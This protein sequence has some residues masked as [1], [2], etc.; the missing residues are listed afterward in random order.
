M[1][2]SQFV[3][4]G[5]FYSAVL[6]GMSDGLYFVDRRRIITYWNKGAEIITG[7]SRAEVVGRSCR[8]N[9]LVHTDCEGCGLCD[10]GCPLI[11][12]FTDGHNREADVFLKHKNGHRVPVWVRVAP[13]MDDSGAVVGG[14]EMFSR[15]DSKLAAFEKASELEKL[16]LI[17]PVTGVGNRRHTERILRDNFER[18][19]RELQSFAVL[20]ID[21]DNFKSVNDQFG[22]DAG[23]AVLRTMAMTL[24]NAVRS[25]DFGGRWGGDEFVAVLENCDE[26]RAKLI[27]TRFGGLARSC[28]VD[29][30]DR[31]IHQTVSIGV[32][33]VRPDDTLDT[34]VKRADVAVYA[35]KEAGR[36]RVVFE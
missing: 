1:P 11:Q 8:D 24:V 28:T 3:P 16:A 36:D 4:D 21:L 32:A 2:N 22:H 14:I 18:F 7:Y 33:V 31:L 29:W 35:A 27:A 20:F 34:L 9:I 17:D 25:C 6:D 23:D 15:S 19:R 5:Q 10:T 30:A 26:D 12:T 13:L